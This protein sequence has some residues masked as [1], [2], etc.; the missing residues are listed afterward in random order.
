LERYPGVEN[1]FT[2]L[3][4]RLE[5]QGLVR[6]ATVGAAALSCFSSRDLYET[7]YRAICADPLFL[8]RADTKPVARPYLRATGAELDAAATAALSCRP[9]T[10]PVARSLSEVMAV[11]TPASAPAM[12]VD[13]RWAGY[14]GLILEQIR[15]HDGLGDEI[16]GMLAFPA[17]ASGRLPA[18]ICLHGTG[19]GWELMM[20]RRLTERGTSLYG[21]PRELARRGFAVLAITQRGHPPRG[22]AWD[23]EWPKLL[24]PYGRSAMGLFAADVAACVDVLSER[25]EIDPARIAI[26]GYSLGGIIAFHSFAID[27]RLRACFTFCGG[28]GSVRTLIREGITRFHSPYYYVPRLLSEGLDH[29]RISEACAPRPLFVIGS[30]EDAGMPASAL[31]A[32]GTEAAEA[33][34]RAGAPA[35]LRVSMHHGPHRVDR[36]MLEEAAAWLPSAA[37]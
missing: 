31:R 34:R 7:G 17:N 37:G 19:E 12:E 28:V 22:E 3:Q 5:A 14:D 2:A 23:W 15:I 32:F 4:E 29:A 25:P 30:E 35:S 26:G 36:A 10:H 33:Y 21:W 24:L 16:P 27:A 1:D 8:V 11:P 13:D 9:A 6:K 18:V 20:E